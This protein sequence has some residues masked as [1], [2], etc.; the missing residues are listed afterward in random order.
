MF[1]EKK[2]TGVGYPT[3]VSIPEDTTCLT[4]QVPANAEWWSV[5]IGLLYTL[6]LEFNWQQFEGGIDRDEAT[7]RWQIMLEDA[8]ELAATTNS[9]GVTEVEAPYWDNSED[10]DD[11]APIDDQPWYGQVADAA[12]APTDLDFVEDATIWA[13]TGLI[14][15]SLGAVGIAPALAFRTAASKFVLSYKNGGEGNII[16]FFVDGVKIYQGTDTGAGEITDVPVVGDP[17]EEM[18][19]IYVTSEIA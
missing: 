13:F 5:T 17:G 14:V 1:G 7:A 9:C 19:Q 16:R 4:L 15:L 6:I 12:V 8:L 10:V 18:H 2:F 3:P 11:N